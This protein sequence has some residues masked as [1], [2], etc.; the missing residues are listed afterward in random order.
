LP[1]SDRRTIAGDA[2][3]REQAES[4]AVPAPTGRGA[5]NLGSTSIPVVGLGMPGLRVGT[6]PI[7]DLDDEQR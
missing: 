4:C 2:W 1:G 7:Y 5:K 3:D 6:T